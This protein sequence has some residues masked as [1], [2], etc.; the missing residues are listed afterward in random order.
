MSRYPVYSVHQQGMVPMGLLALQEVSGVNFKEQIHKGMA[1]IYG[2]NELHTDLRDQSRNV[3]WRCIRHK[4]RVENL[5]GVFRNIIGLQNE[6]ASVPEL[7]I[8]FEDWP[9]ELGQC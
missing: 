4:K 8:L 1:W 3:I 5:K 2:K 7:E 9:Y 6:N